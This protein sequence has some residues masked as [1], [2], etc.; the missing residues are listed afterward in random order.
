[1]IISSGDSLTEII[2]WTEPDVDVVVRNAVTLMAATL[3]ARAI[4]TISSHVW[5]L[6]TNL[7][8]LDATL[9]AL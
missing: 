1:M 6:G 3:G 7:D 8:T 4:F 5:R 2:G 9:A